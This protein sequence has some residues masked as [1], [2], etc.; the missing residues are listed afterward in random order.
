VT[1]IEPAWPAWK[2]GALPL[3]YTRERYSPRRQTRRRGRRR[4]QTLGSLKFSA[5]FYAL[6]LALHTADHFRRGLDASTGQVLIVGNLSTAIGITVVVMVIVGYRH[7]PLLAALTG[8]PA[9]FGVA[10]VHLLP[11]CSAFSDAFVD[12]HNTGVT[13][14]SWTVVLIE[15]AG[16]LAMGI[17]G[18][19]IVRDQRA[20]ANVTP[21]G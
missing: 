15:I 4:S 1:G 12:A 3:S 8:F 2:A 5:L 11:T 6:G 13:A 14:M 20:A 16:A 7:A 10:A 9:A 18:L 19:A 21:S 17:V